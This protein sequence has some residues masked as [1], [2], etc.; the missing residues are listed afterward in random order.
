[1]KLPPFFLPMVAGLGLASCTTMTAPDGTVT[2]RP[3]GETITTAAGLIET[4]LN[5]L[6]ET[7]R[8]EGGSK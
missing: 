5:L 3:D 4:A 1:M 7:R 8:V 6:S 2:K